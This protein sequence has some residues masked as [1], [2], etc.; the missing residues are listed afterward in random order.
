M[1]NSLG[2]SLSRWLGSGDYTVAENSI[3]QKTLRGSDNIPSMH[4]TDQTIVVRHREF[5]T[6]LTSS[7]GF[8]VR[9]AFS[10]NPGLKSTFPWLS[11]I[12]QNYQEYKIKGL[13]FHY[14]PTS[15]MVTG[16]NTA[17]GAV[18]FQ[19][20]YRASDSQPTTKYELLNEFWSNECLP[21]EAMCHPI[22]CKPS[23]TVLTMRYVRDGSVPDDLMF[24][25]YGTTIVAVQGQ[26][27][28]GQIIGDVWVTYEVE[29][30]KPKMNASLGRS[31]TSFRSTNVTSDAARWFSGSAVT[32]SSFTGNVIVTS[33]AASTHV[34]TFPPGNAGSYLVNIGLAGLSSGTGTPVITLSN[35]SA[36]TNGLESSLTPTSA[37]SVIRGV[38]IYAVTIN[39]PT[40]AATVTLTG[41]STTSAG[42][43]TCDVFITALDAD[44]ATYL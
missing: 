26:Q 37:F 42:N 38:V 34:I 25:D 22:E 39:D 1:G 28:V 24:Y 32:F 7:S 12:A 8:A 4:R 44:T 21:S 30:R 13:V 10:L 17:L 41:V 27:S 20:T 40:T 31:V 43:Y 9:A 14:V 2:A 6:T 23:E 3:V 35:C 11:Q 19:T 36:L 18:M 33:P 15:G 5:L 29:L 16:S